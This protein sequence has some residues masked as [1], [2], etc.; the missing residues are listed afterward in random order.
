MVPAERVLGVGHPGDRPRRP[1]GVE[2][3]D[4]VPALGEQHREPERRTTVDAHVAVGQHGAALL[5][6]GQCEVDA[7]VEPL[8]RHPLPRVVDAVVQVADRGCELRDPVLVAP[9][10]ACVDDV[11]QPGLDQ[12][13]QL[14]DRELV[15]LGVEVA[16]DQEVV[17]DE[18]RVS[19]GQLAGRSPSTSTLERPD[20]HGDKP[21]QRAF[22][23][24]ASGLVAGPS[25]T[26]PSELNRDPCRGQ[27]Q[28]LS[29]SFQ[30]SSPP[31]CV[32]TP[33]TSHGRSF[34]TRSTT[35]PRSGQADLRVDRRQLGHRGRTDRPPAQRPGP[36][37]LLTQDPPGDRPGSGDP[38]GHPPL[39]EA[40]GDVDA[41]QAP[42]QQ[43]D[44]RHA[45]VR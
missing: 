20:R 43:A 1:D 45:V 5:D 8:P 24:R 42:G 31:R 17:G 14:A 38:V 19:G 23:R 18:V 27:S 21:L 33:K 32:Q 40:G 11:R 25:R 10:D 44:E 35:D 29:T 26:D 22:E 3:L 36:G 6:R 34:R 41:S 37:R 30:C 16:T 28:E 13:G 4:R 9:L 39:V 7:G 2:R 15:V 12:L